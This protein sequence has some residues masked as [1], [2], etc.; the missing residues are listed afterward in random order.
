MV[1]VASTIVSA[2]LVFITP[3]QTSAVIIDHIENGQREI[4]DTENPQH[5]GC[6]S[7]T[8]I[9]WFPSNGSG[10]P[11]VPPGALSTSTSTS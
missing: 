10:L 11:A 6:E 7:T 8:M 4:Y 5:Q 3:T 9:C 1:I 2:L